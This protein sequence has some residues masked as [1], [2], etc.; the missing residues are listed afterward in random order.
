MIPKKIQSFFETTFQKRTGDN[1]LI[2]GI[3]TC[4]NSH[5]FEVFVV[6]EIKHSIFC[7][8]CLIPENDEIELEVRCKNCGRVLSVFD[9]CCDGYEQCQNNQPTHI[10]NKPINCIKC[11]NGYFSVEIKYEY[12]DIQELE[13][14]EIKEID[15][16]FTW[17]WITLKCNRCGTIYNNF[18]DYETD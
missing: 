6:G 11:Q 4:C 17:I 16:A 5:D 15:N 13:E 10:L 14:L 12:P 8:M 1:N 7:R 18:I 3:L 2:K 9:S